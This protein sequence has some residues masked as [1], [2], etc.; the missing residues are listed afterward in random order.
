MRRAVPTGDTGEGGIRSGRRRGWRRGGS[1]RE[2]EIIGNDGGKLAAGK[3]DDVN[4]ER[5][6]MYT[7]VIHFLMVGLM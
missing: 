7:K 1:R 2:K 3:G 5:Q 6:S 4:G